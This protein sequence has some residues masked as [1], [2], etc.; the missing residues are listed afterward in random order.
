V[1]QVRFSALYRHEWQ[2]RE[3]LPL[4]TEMESEGWV[5][6]GSVDSADVDRLRSLGLRVQLV[7]WNEEPLR[8]SGVYLPSRLLDDL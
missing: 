4:L 5:I 1:A 2:Y 6:T 3:C 7:S 8:P